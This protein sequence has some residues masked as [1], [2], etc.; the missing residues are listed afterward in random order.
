MTEP[1]NAADAPECLSCGA[2]CFSSLETYVRV[3]GADYA[4]LGEHAETL[5]CFDGNRAYLR[6]LD[7]HCAALHIDGTTRRFVCSVYEVR[8]ATCREL[9]RGGG[10]CAG[11]RE[12]KAERPLLALS[13]KRSRLA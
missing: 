8:P 10:A 7:G 2:C 1:P 4:R 3:T 13:R 9:E 11:E 12:V 5:V 6:M